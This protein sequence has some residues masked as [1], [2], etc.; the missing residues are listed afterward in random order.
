MTDKYIW[1]WGHKTISGSKGEGWQI[2]LTVNST[3][4]FQGIKDEWQARAIAVI[5]NAETSSG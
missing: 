4:L 2:L 5:L 3:V 1:G